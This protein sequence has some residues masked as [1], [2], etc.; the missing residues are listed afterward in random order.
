MLLKFSK[1]KMGIVL[2]LKQTMHLLL[3]ASIFTMD[4]NKL[5]NTYHTITEVAFDTIEYVSIFKLCISK[6]TP[7]K[8]NGISLIHVI[9]LKSA[10]NDRQLTLGEHYNNSQNIQLFNEHTVCTNNYS[11]L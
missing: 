4:G 1:I 3:A 6:F 8:S 5:H 11:S 2:Y 7:E 10:Q 9:T